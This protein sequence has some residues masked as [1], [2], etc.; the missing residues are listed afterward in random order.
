MSRADR[1]GLYLFVAWVS[2][3]LSYEYCYSSTLFLFIN[4]RWDYGGK[5]ENMKKLLLTLMTVLISI[6]TYS[7]SLGPE[8]IASSGDYFTSSNVKLSWT[9]GEMV[10]ETFSV[11]GNSLTQGFQQGNYLYAFVAENSE[12]N[13][14]SV[15]PN[16]FSNVIII[17]TSNLTGLMVQV[18]DIQGKN[19]MERTIEKSNKRLDFSAFNQGI[20]FIKVMNKTTLL[21]SFKIQKIN[22]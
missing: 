11:S 9:L 22:N 14:I 2:Q 7:Q 10:T 18:F 8:V 20:Y 13:N 15:F 21:K 5:K 4:L 1:R 12:N 16:P 3:C 17:N 6:W 19:L